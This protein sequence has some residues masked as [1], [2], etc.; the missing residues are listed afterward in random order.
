MWG[1]GGLQTDVLWLNVRDPTYPQKRGQLKM[2]LN[3]WNEAFS[4]R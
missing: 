4:V 2:A 1:S 3:D